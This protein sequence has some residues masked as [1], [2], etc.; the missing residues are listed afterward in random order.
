[1]KYAIHPVAGRMPGHVNVLLA[2]AEVPYGQVFEME[3]IN[4][5]FGRAGVV[6]GADYVV[7]CRRA[8]IRSPINDIEAIMRVCDI[9]QIKAG[10]IPFVS[11]N[12]LLSECLF[13]MADN[14][15]GSLAV[16]E[17]GTLVG[18]VTFREIFSAMA[19]HHRG[20]N[21]EHGPQVLG[22]RARHIMNPTPIVIDPEMG[23]AELRGLMV[24]HSLRYVPMVSKG[25]FL[26]I[27]S[28]HDVA[29]AVHEE[30]AFENRM[31]KSYIG[32]WPAEAIAVS[33]AAESSL[34]ASC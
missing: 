17:R 18:L 26:G 6:L 11:P 22:I 1:M 4:G 34:G 27:I 3:D 31:L 16:V 28:F 8:G 14:D 21:M 30:Q 24:Q 15:L 29:K 19:Q 5:E 2:E 7:G 12:T 9:L 20:R 32:D 25:D 23:I 10:P 33:L 13:V